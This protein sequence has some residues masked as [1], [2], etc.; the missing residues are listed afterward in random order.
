MPLDL[1]NSEAELKNCSH[2][3]RY[4]WH[5]IDLLKTWFPSFSKWGKIRP[6][7]LHLRK[8]LNE[9]AHLTSMESTLAFHGN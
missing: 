9:M 2:L 1:E 5:V 3:A 4:M 8:G 7:L 6:N